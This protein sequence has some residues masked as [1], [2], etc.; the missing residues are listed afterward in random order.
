MYIYIC[1]CIIYN[2]IYKYNISNIYRYIL[3]IIYF[4]LRHGNRQILS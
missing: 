1:I 4:K 2:N 3:Y